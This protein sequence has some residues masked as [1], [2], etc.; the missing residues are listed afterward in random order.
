MNFGSIGMFFMHN[1]YF[2]RMKIIMKTFCEMAYIKV[3]YVRK[4]FLK[5]HLERR[6]NGLQDGTKQ[7][8]IYFILLR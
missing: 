8:M 3:I 7:Y 5:Q 6:K 2:Y 1:I 4:N